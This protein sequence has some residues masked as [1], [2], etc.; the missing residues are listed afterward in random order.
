MEKIFQFEKG[1]IDIL[2]TTSIIVVKNYLPSCIL[3]LA[4]FPSWKG[5]IELSLASTRELMILFGTMAMAIIATKYFVI[6]EN[7]LTEA[8]FRK[9]IS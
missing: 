6:N 4:S 3:S 1:F 5:M 7:R 9:K 2:F 8:I